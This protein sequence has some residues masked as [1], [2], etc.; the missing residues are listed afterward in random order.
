ME[1]RESLHLNVDEIPYSCFQREDDPVD[2][3]PSAGET[4]QYL[5]LAWC[6]NAVVRYSSLMFE[7]ELFEA[8]GWYG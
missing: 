2:I 6:V 5:K 3:V 4:E 7:S 8:L 1:H